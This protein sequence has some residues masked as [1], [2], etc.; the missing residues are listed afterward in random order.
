MSCKKRGRVHLAP[1]GHSLSSQLSKPST[2][3]SRV[4]VAVFLALLISMEAGRE[5]AN[6]YLQEAEGGVG[7]EM[8]VSFILGVKHIVN[9]NPVLETPWMMA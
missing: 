9:I 6:T 7:L 4:E 2:F 5:W 3:S 1:D 8:G